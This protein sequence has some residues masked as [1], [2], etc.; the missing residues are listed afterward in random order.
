M[1]NNECVALFCRSLRACPLQHS[2]CGV[3]LLVGFIKA[4]VLGFGLH[5]YATTNNE[6]RKLKSGRTAGRGL[7]AAAVAT[8]VREGVLGAR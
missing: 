7:H 5:D 3:L 1:T 4:S 8:R 2:W 6:K